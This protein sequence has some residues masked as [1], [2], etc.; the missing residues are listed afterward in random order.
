MAQLEP[1]TIL[2]IF[3]TGAMLGSFINYVTEEIESISLE[4]FKSYI[5]SANKSLTSKLEIFKIKS[6]LKFMNMFGLNND[7]VEWWA[8]TY[9]RVKI[10]WDRRCYE[11][12]N[13][14]EVLISKS[15]KDLNECLIQ[16]CNFKFSE[17]STWITDEAPYNSFLDF[18]KNIDR[19]IISI[20]HI[21]FNEILP[22]EGAHNDEIFISVR[23]TFVNKYE[24]LNSDQ[25]SGSLILPPVKVKFLGPTYGLEYKNKLLLENGNQKLSTWK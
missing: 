23:V 21:H 13:F 4:S 16:R 10:Y 1:I 11:D 18:Y 17:D 3:M 15:F 6:R 14:E 5:Y 7:P 19:G 22:Y 25:F 9:V 8:D 2:E 12:K 24:Y 20:I